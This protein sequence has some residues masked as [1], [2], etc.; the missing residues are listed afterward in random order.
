MPMRSVGF[1]L[2]T[3]GKA[4]VKNDFAEVKAAGQAS[5]AGVADAAED[6]AERSARAAD[7]FTERQLASF[8]KQ[9]NAAKLAA[10]GVGQQSALD[11]ALS[12]RGN[13][14][15]FATVNLDRSTGAA[16]ES[17]AVFEAA[18]EAERLA[19]RA[20]EDRTAAVVKLRAALDPLSIAQARY[21]ADVASADALHKAGAIST[22]EHASAMR[23][24]TQRLDE[25][26]RGLDG[27]AKAEAE[28]EAAATRLRAQLDPLWAAQKRYDDELASH[29]NL[30]SRGLINEAE[31]GEAVKQSGQRL[32]EARRALEGH[33]SA[34]GLNRMQMVVGAGAARNFMDSVLAG[35]SPM[36][37]FMQQAGDVAT[38]LEM[39]D[40]GV[41]GGLAKVRSLLTPTTVAIGATTLAVALGAKAWLDY[42]GSIAKLQSLSM[43]SGAALGLDGQQLQEVAEQAARA[44]DMT[45]GAAREIE[46]AYVQSGNATKAVLSDLIVA[47][48]DF[49][50]ATGQD[51]AGA[52]KQLDGALA[53]PIAGAQMLAERYGWISTATADYIGKLIEENRLEEAQKALID[54]VADGTRGAADQANALARGWD[55]VKLSAAGAWEW[56]GKAIDRA[57][58]GGSIQDQIASL[59]SRR[60]L[61]PSVG[62]MLTGTTTAAFQADIDRQ[63]ADLRGQMRQEANRSARNAANSDRAAGQAIVDRFSGA[64]QLGSYRSAA[65][66]L[67]AALATDMPPDQRRQ[68]TETLSAYTHA[69]DT[70]IPRQEKSNQL[71]AL[72]AKL[73]AAKTPAEKAALSAQRQRLELA[74]TVISAADAD[75]RAV[76]AGDRARSQAAR[77]GASH[78]QA[79]A[80]EAQSM[81]VSARAALDV[82][83]AYL[84][85]SAAGVSAEALRK[86]STDAT[87]KGIDVEAQAR[88]QMNLQTAEAIANGAKSVASLH[89]ETGA[90]ADVLKQVQDGTLST[91]GMANA[92]SDEAA[93]RPLIKLQTLAQGSALEVLNRVIAQYR[94]ELTDAHKVEAQTGLDKSISASIERV[95]DLKAA[96]GDLDASPVDAAVSAAQRSA[97]AELRKIDPD[98][99]ASPADHRKFINSRMDEARQ[100]FA[101]DRARYLRDAKRDEQDALELSARELQLVG[102]SSD[103]R[104]LEIA[105]LR[106]QQDIRRRFGDMD[107][108]DVQAR[109]AAI[110]AQ[111][112]VNAKLK[113]TAAAIDEVREFGTGLV[114]DVLNPSNWDNWGDAGK[115]V[116]KDI[117][118]EFL[119]LALINPLK[120][121]INGNKDLPTLSSAISNIGSLFGKKTGKNASGTESWSGGLTWVNENGPEIADLPN[122]TRIYPAAETRRMMTANENGAGGGALHFD[123]RGAVVTQDLLDQMN[124]MANGAAV[125]GAAGGSQ[126]AQRDLART[127]RRSLSRG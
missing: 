104:D 106:V 33:T 35:A 18:A 17:A 90:R 107:A 99:L 81:E 72:D 118:S 105:K 28:A 32:N 41:A 22:E 85:S 52:A 117:K 77:S 92:L 7:Q 23:L 101:A 40:G 66:K 12:Q 58:T 83:G 65:G 103:V 67:R 61:G 86:A 116:L 53:D 51:A 24:F 109:L 44:G 123:L 3:D 26:R 34:L 97:A 56:L 30:L 76:A 10:A 45:V 111:D 57:A 93:L 37:A 79:L 60:A 69:I 122:G 39:D 49:A 9:A 127:R 95:E 42:S 27:T 73:A 71:A 126:M 46:Q 20:D 89:E 102:A 96:M 14:G 21:S 112:Q 43:G 113:I 55:N 29:N 63:I 8:R 78:A 31:H 98:N 1:Q 11:E 120:N 114:D 48:K 119:K 88:R 87:R 70:F 94:Q 59:Q 36:R 25:N 54:A 115:A 80:R 38:V 2:R 121:M 62:Q 108:A 82:A 6:A 64:D 68:L 50:A 13:G 16:R 5:M 75:T 125:R 74:G 4:E 19:T 15:Q 124:A 47:T 110:D 84:K 100:G 91:E